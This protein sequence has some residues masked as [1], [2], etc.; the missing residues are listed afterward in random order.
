[1]Y[2]HVIQCQHSQPSKHFLLR[3]RL[4]IAATSRRLLFAFVSS[5]GLSFGD[6]RD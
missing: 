2:L 1:M 5:H 4:H 6:P 3:N